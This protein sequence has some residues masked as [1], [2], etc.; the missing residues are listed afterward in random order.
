M[1]PF[2][3][4]ALDALSQLLKSADVKITKSRL[5]SI[6]MRHPHF[7]SL[8][9]LKDTLSDCKIK[10][11]AA[12][13]TIGKLSGIPLPALVF[14]TIEG[15]IFAP[16]RRVT[17]SHVEWYHTQNGW[18][19][20]TLYGF[21]QKWSGA[22]LLIEP[23]QD[24]NEQNYY[25]KRIQEH[26]T[27]ALGPFVS[28]LFVTF[29]VFL[30][31]KQYGTFSMHEAGEASLLVSIKL[32]GAILSG[33]LVWQGIDLTGASVL[34]PAFNMIH[35][36]SG[37]NNLIQS[38]AAFLF[39]GI[40][41]SETGLIYFC[42][43]TLGIMV[44][45]IFKEHI[46]YQ[47]FLFN[48]AS[49]PFT[50]YLF[51]IQFNRAKE[52]CL[53]CSAILI[54]FW[55][56]F[57]V[58]CYFC[59][60]DGFIQ[61]FGGLTLIPSLLFT[62]ALYFLI[63]PFIAAKRERDNVLREF[64][65]MKFNQALI[66]GILKNKTQLPPVF[67][68]MKILCIG[69]SSAELGI[70]LVYG[71]T[72][73]ES[74]KL[75]QQLKAQFNNLNNFR[76]QIIFLPTSLLDAEIIDA[77]LNCPAQASVHALEKWFSDIDQP[78]EKWKRALGNETATLKDEFKTQVSL[79]SNWCNLAKISAIPSIFINDAAIPTIYQTHDL[80]ILI[81]SA[82]K[83]HQQAQKR[84]LPSGMK[85]ITCITNPEEIGYKHALKAS[86]H[87]FNLE[88]IT[89]I[90]PGQ[91]D[92]HRHKDTYLKQ[93]LLSLPGDEVI[94]FTDGYD[95]ILLGGEK[96]IMERYR[97]I[98]PDGGIVISSEKTCYPD[99]NLANT[100][101]MTNTPYRFL[102]SGGI[103]GTAAD[104][105]NALDEIE[106]MKSHLTDDPFQFSN[107]YL[108][109]RIML[110]EGNSRIKLDVNC[111]LFQTFPTTMETVRKFQS[112]S[113]IDEKKNIVM[114]E[115]QV[116]LHDFEVN[117]GRNIYNKIT[118][119]YPLHLH[120]NGPVMKPGML[121]QP[122]LSFINKVNQPTSTQERSI[123]DDVSVKE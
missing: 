112:V 86:C 81:H 35:E 101:P 5:G 50:V 29:I 119:T 6:L 95:T 17:D 78:V 1:N 79:H 71:P 16:V 76:W 104:I 24:S 39:Y 18:Q 66:D 25:F 4:N 88:L 65:K 70:T 122:F 30:F 47:I 49:L 93:Y 45:A 75:H 32:I 108:W 3:R 59:T 109:T 11:I 10:T 23:T 14:L 82:T 62:I 69:D 56:E 91:W 74:A 83:L 9:S 58:C 52:F 84:S 21:E 33:L 41:Y 57:V 27:S 120:F 77:L 100:Y 55:M 2:E 7:P 107:Q 20:D 94:F 118:G 115:M 60:M 61:G 54:M 48:L 42:G 44:A 53:L 19:N 99:P 90:H 38:K 37:R 73:P 92:S 68:G 40:S 121:V 98:A 103:I 46:Y 102:N 31:W 87:F 89:L 85:I 43:T 105:L 51:Y 63:K 67:D 123:I 15:G 72:N 36:R 110:K 34:R 106:Q 117:E 97:R 111:E 13:G 113:D 96:E 114:T 28:I 22:L 116:I 8:A 64:K 12:R 80:P 26:I